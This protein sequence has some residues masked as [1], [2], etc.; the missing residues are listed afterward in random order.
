MTINSTASLKWSAI[1]FAM[2]WTV[3]MVWWSA[4]VQPAN[5]IILAV[6]GTLAGYFWYLGMRWFF[7]RVGSSAAGEGADDRET[8]HGR[9]HARLVWAALMISTGLATAFLHALADPYIPAGD[10]HT[11]LSGLFVIVCWPA[12]VWALRPLVKRHLPA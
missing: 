3:W 8:S 4:S 9:V 5:V 11:L 12:L 2:L 10:W 7:H 6:C 1:L